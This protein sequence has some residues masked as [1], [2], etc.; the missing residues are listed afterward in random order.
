MPQFL[1][2]RQMLENCGNSIVL[3]ELIYTTK[4]KSVRRKPNQRRFLRA[5]KIKRKK[6]KKNKTV[7]PKD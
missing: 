6:V 3:V 2:L 4:C 1:K 7:N 5:S